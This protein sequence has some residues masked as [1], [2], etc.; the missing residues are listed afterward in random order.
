VVEP[1]LEGQTIGL[2]SYAV[3]YLLQGATCYFTSVF[4]EI[5]PVSNH[6]RL[7]TFV[8]TTFNLSK[9]I[10]ER[11]DLNG[12]VEIGEVSPDSTNLSFIDEDPLQGV[13]IYRAIA[14]L[15]NGAEITSEETDIHVLTSLPVL[16]FPNPVE[17][18]DGFSAFTRDFG[19]DEVSFELYNL[20][21]SLVLRDIIDNDRKNFS[22]AGL[23]EGIYIYR[24]TGSGISETGKLV[25]N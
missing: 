17:K 10:V 18:P 2:R 15:K 7:N 12:F 19:D 5:I 20:Q 9:I 8:G 1:V 13:N 11:F 14:V 3:N 25:I 6:V 4:P 21:G 24:I 23:N 22:S 16:I